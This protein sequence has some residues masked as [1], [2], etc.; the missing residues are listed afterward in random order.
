MKQD[1]KLDQ[2]EPKPGVCPE[3]IKWMEYGLKLAEKAEE[4]GE[5]PIGAVIVKA[6]TIIG[7]GWNQSITR[8]DASAHAEIMA[9]RAAGQSEN[10]YR[11]VGGT[12]Y[13]TLEPC[14]MCAGALVHSRIERLVYGARD[15]K[16]GAVESVMKLLDH[17]SHNHKV[18]YQGGCCESACG[19]QISNFFKRRRA[20][21]KQAKL[22]VKT[23]AQLTNGKEEES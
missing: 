17:E 10:N 14:P 7:E 4:Q 2:N 20:E 15:Y 3:D 5:I 18:Q 19:E 9:M 21:K 1:S 6:G 22:I 23:Q 12:L 13:V 8:N 11:L 16:T